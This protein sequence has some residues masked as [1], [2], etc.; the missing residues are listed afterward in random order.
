M[1][2]GNRGLWRLYQ[3]QQEKQNLTNQIHHLQE[4]IA[5]YQEEVTAVNKNPSILEKQARVELNLVR[6]GEMVYKFLKKKNP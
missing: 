1:I 4:D 5:R 3:L 2:T 6:P